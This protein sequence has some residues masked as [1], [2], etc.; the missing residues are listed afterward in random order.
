MLFESQTFCL[1]PG[2]P[3][4]MANDNDND[5]NKL[6]IFSYAKCPGLILFLCHHDPLW[7]NHTFLL[8]VS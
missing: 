2:H 5:L 7:P 8:L 4:V 6:Y 1:H 3:R